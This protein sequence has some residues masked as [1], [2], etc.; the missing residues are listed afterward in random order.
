MNNLIPYALPSITELEISYVN[1]AISNGWGESR[2]KYLDQLEE[3][4]SKVIGADKTIA[5][6]SCTGALQL[7]LSALGIGPGD[8]VIL[9]DTNWIATVAPVVHLGAKPI[10]VDI[11]PKNW[12]IDPNRVEE[13]I[14]EKTKAVIATHLYG[15]LA[16]LDSINEV[17]SKKEIFLIE[18]AAEAIGSFYKGRAAGSIG[19]F[20]VFS[21]H[22]SKTVTTGEGGCLV[23]SDLNLYEKALVLSNHG[24]SENDPGIFSPQKLGYKFKM[25]NVQAA[26]GC[27]QVERIKELVKK[28][29]EILETYRKLFSKDKNL[30]LNLVQSNCENGA[31]M[32]TLEVEGRPVVI[33]ETIELGLRSLGIDARPVFKPLS[34]L[35][36]FSEKNTRRNALSFSQSALNLP[37]FHTMTNGQIEFVAESIFDILSSVD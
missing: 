31:W 10:F 28:K 17:I 19:K 11:D 23:T 3:M 20:G 6:S 24:R 35:P 4:F 18:D 8:E 16:D 15:N 1:D 5:T 26:I 14:T 33:S 36:M 22:G 37:S 21:F 7:G 30:K 12:C 2:S 29:Q 25:S 32:P 13:A 34:S 27:G 9:A